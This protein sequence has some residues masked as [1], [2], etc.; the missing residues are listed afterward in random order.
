MIHIISLGPSGSPYNDIF[1]ILYGHTHVAPSPADGAASGLI[2]LA[3]ELI[4]SSRLELGLILPDN[5]DS[6]GYT[7]KNAHSAFIS[8]AV[9]KPGM[10]RQRSVGTW[11]SWLNW[12]GLDVFCST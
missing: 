9:K 7:L 3:N 6:I 10:M 4:R 2:G 8:F 11:L 12:I 1:R 5:L